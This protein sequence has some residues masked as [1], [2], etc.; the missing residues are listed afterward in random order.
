MITDSKIQNEEKNVRSKTLLVLG[1]T[2]LLPVV[3][4]LIFLY[5]NV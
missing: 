1:L 5:I 4:T 3:I 2:F